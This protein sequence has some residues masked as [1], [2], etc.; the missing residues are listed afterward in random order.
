MEGLECFFDF[1][2]Q[3]TRGRSVESSTLISI[4]INLLVLG[5]L[6]YTA[7]MQ[8]QKIDALTNTVDSLKET[9]LAQE[10]VVSAM[11]KWNQIIDV[12][13]LAKNFKT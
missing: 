3:M 2:C 9:I 13:R 11:E 4:I 10:K 5:C 8:K 7:R 12:E 1:R 6:V